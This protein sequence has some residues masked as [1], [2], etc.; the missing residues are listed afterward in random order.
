MFYRISKVLSLLSITLFLASGCTISKLQHEGLQAAE[1]KRQG[2]IS[3]ADKAEGFTGGKV[4]WGRLTPFAIPVAPV[5]I[6][7]DE[8]KQLM[9]NVRE[10]LEMAGYTVSVEP[11]AIDE[12]KETLETSGYTVVKEIEVKTEKTPI[13]K[14]V[15]D[16]ISFSNYTWLAPIVPT[17]GGLDVTLQ[18]VSA[19][20]V[21]LWSEKFEGG[22]FTFNFFDGYN[23]ASQESMSELL[24]KMVQSFSG[25]KF[26]QALSGDL[27]TSGI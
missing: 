22:G 15:V 19:N 1:N 10:A 7:G 17:W 2:S 20:G 26:Y 16:D 11:A 18:L 25:D 4:G 23:I 9:E 5:Y 8:S 24:G 21:V 13:L 27:V 6:H 14:C 12:L 3:V